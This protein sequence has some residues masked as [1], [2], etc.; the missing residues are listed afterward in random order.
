MRAHRMRAHCLGL[1][2]AAG[3]FAKQAYSQEPS[4]AQPL[5]VAA[6]AELLVASGH[7]LTDDQF[8][9]ACSATALRELAVPDCSRLTDEG[10]SAVVALTQLRSLDVSNCR[11]LTA[12]SFE[13]IAQLPHL[14]RLNISSTRANLPEV[15]GW[16]EG[17][18]ELTHLEVCDIG[19]FTSVGLD[20]LPGLKYLDI[21][22]KGGGL[23]DE[24]LAPLASLTELT[25]LK[26]NGSRV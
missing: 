22:N 10:L 17:S 9:R 16:L 23:T 18:P 25:Y 1:L 13:W 26:V 8:R 3:L 4:A 14:E 2:L 11:R 20:R 24:H 5:D 6:A 7:D 15:Y 19:D 21:S 12:A